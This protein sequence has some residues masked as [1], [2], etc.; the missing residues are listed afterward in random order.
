[1]RI[2][3]LVSGKGTNLQALIDA[4]ARGELAPA[5]IACVISNRDGASSPR[6]GIPAK[7][8][9]HGKLSRE[10]F[11]DQLLANLGLHGVE[12]VVLAGFMRIL[13]A[14][15]IDR[16]PCRIINTHPSLLPAFPGADAPAQAIAHGVKLSGVT[17]HFVDAS[18][19]GGPVI[20]QVAVPVED[21]DDAGALHAR[22]QAEEHRLLPDVVR[23]LA[24]GELVCKGRRVTR[25]K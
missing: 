2:G 25:A 21:D 15:F 23:R 14:H 6:A 3:V 13:T 7:V 1:V 17:V 19:D 18:L 12:A 24:R 20:A 5:T 9:P 22:I 16:F 4:E 11:E 10:E 8:V